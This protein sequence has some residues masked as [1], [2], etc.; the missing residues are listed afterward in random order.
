MPK[1]KDVPTSLNIDSIE[2]Y[3]TV[4]Q[5]LSYIEKNNISGDAKIFLERIPD[6]YFTD[7]NWPVIFQEGTAADKGEM[8]QYIVAEGVF[9]IDGNLYLHPTP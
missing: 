3:I 7:N 9:E 4:K 8:D 5:L 6:H 2:D 1:Y